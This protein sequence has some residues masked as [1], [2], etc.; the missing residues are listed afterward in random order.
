MATFLCK[1]AAI[2]ITFSRG[3]MITPDL[4][5]DEITKRASGISSLCDEHFSQGSKG[6]HQGSAGEK[7]ATVNFD[8]QHG[9]LHKVVSLFFCRDVDELGQ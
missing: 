6:S 4:A 2:L 7:C 3:K 8:H 9:L 1:L 5:T